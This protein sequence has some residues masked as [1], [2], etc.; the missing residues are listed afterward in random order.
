ML[1]EHQVASLEGKYAPRSGVITKEVAQEMVLVDLKRSLYH[2]LN[3]VGV[4]IWKRLDGQ[5]PLSEIVADM[6]A[7]HADVEP[8]TI[9][10]DTLALL[11]ALIDN[12]LVVTH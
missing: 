3:T 8:T 12:E 2:G 5:K 9:E 10:G 11:Q 4:Q 6:Q 1:M 7:I